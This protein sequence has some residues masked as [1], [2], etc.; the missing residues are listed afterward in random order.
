VGWNGV[1]CA[2]VILSVFQLLAIPSRDG[3]EFGLFG[4][5]VSIDVSLGESVLGGRMPLGTIKQR[6][7]DGTCMARVRVVFGCAPPA[8]ECCHRLCW[9][10]AASGTARMRSARTFRGLSVCAK[11][12]T[13]L[14]FLFDECLHPKRNVFHIGLGTSFTGGLSTRWPWHSESEGLGHAHGCCHRDWIRNGVL[15]LA[16]E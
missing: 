6:P 8:P 3:L 9:L 4:L 5:S 15:R 11:S 2:G 13:P 10:C 7:S 16:R 14:Q 12:R 1:I